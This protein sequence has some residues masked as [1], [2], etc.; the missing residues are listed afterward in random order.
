MNSRYAV[1]AA[2]RTVAC[3]GVR[4]L[5]SDQ[6]RTMHPSGSRRS[7]RGSCP[8]RA[9][10]SRKPSGS[11]GH[12]QGVQSSGLP[13]KAPTTRGS[14]P[15][16]IA[17][18]RQYWPEWVHSAVRFSPPPQRDPIPAFSSTEKTRRVEGHLITH[19]VVAG[20][21]HFVCQRS[22][23]HHGVTTRFLAV[24]VSLGERLVFLR[25]M[26]SFRIGP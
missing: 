14:R 21:R 3:P 23:S 4:G 17:G 25:V 18:E 22:R 24:E 15:G 1:P 2:F 16:R 11:P 5:V 19:H 8:S 26:G 20:P 12:V 10:R 6:V 13:M 9:S 7:S